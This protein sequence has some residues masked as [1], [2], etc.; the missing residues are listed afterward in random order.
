M[1]G[2]AMT[3]A[4]SWGG[5]PGRRSGPRGAAAFIPMSDYTGSQTKGVLDGQ[6]GHSMTLTIKLL[7]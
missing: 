5:D 2:A 7:N 3:M 4:R 6:T 1:A